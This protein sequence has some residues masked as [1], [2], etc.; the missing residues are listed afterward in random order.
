MECEMNIFTLT[1]QFQFL[2]NSMAILACIFLCAEFIYI[3]RVRKPPY[4]WS[5]Y[6]VA[7]FLF[8][9]ACQRLVTVSQPRITEEPWHVISQ[10]VTDLLLVLCMILIPLVRRETYKRPKFH[11]L[12]RIN[13]ELKYSQQLF[14]S[15]L[16]E[17]PAVAYIKDKERRV[18]QLNNE[19]RRLFHRQV[20]DALGK[21]DLWGDPT[22]SRERD[23]QILSGTADKQVT[24]TMQVDG[25]PCVIY[26]IRFPLSG[27]NNETMLGGIVVDITERL[28]WKNKVEVFASIVELAPDAIYVYDDSRNVFTWNSAA[29]RLYGYS[30]DE[31]IGQ[32]IE[33]IVP[34]DKLEELKAFIETLRDS[35]HATARIDT[36]RIARDGSRIPM[37]IAAARVP[38]LSHERASFAIVARD[39]TQQVQVA[40]QIAALHQELEAKVKELSFTNADLQKARDQAIESASLKSAFVA[41]ISHEL[42]TPLSGI[43]GMSEL[44]CHRSLDDD[45]GRMLLMMQESSMGLLH[46]VN[47]ILDLARLEAGKITVEKTEIRVRDLAQDCANLFCPSA[48]RKGLDLTVSIDS[49]VPEWNLCDQAIIRQVLM[50]LLSNAIKFTSKGGITLAVELEQSSD[51]PVSL[52]FTVADS[53][54]GIAKQQL[55]TLLTPMM[56]V[57][58]AP[59][60]SAGAGLGLVV[61]K[62]LVELIGGRIGCDSKEGEGASFWFTVPVEL[63]QH[64][65]GSLREEV[66]APQ[67]ELDLSSFKVLSVDDSP[68]IS[69]VTVFQ[70]SSL[71]VQAACAATG[72][73]ALSRVSAENFDLILMDVMLPDMTGFE[74]AQK[75]R[76]LERLKGKPRSVI[77]AFTGCS[78]QSDKEEAAA[79]GM[80]GFLTKPA[81]IESLKQRLVSSLYSRNPQPE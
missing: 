15:Y 18:I 76:E 75:I 24:E 8:S 39:T 38:G 4:P 65:E 50:N 70:L 56:Q 19:Y 41:N 31:M 16:E 33:K 20:E 36:V 37:Q 7:L 35:E 57:N 59:D 14:K 11:Q 2:L 68:T 46:V 69:R 23:E 29:E 25:S 80:D 30:R 55:E 48:A 62:R 72:D 22:A 6:A 28:K 26:D 54:T 73:E 51:Q 63:L 21:T 44:L 79:A 60:G 74:A 9:L 27:P 53:G 10:C 47:D 13:E 61:S 32:S 52:K 49:S 71:G 40:E 78:S 5:S 12:Q 66:E 67:P 64:A 42:R 81:D 77:I 45:A 17:A 58:Q 1:Y 43:L 3:V 34:D